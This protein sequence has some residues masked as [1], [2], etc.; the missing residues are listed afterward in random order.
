MY[1]NIRLFVFRLTCE[2]DTWV[3]TESCMFFFFVDSLFMKIF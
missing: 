2:N 3:E 1:E